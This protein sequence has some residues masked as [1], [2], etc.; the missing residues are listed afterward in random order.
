MI[1]LMKL[2]AIIVNS[3]QPLSIVLKSFIFDAAGVLGPPL[4]I[5]NFTQTKLFF[6]LK[7]WVLLIFIFKIIFFVKH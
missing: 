3:F 1:F 2:F 7:Q 5:A 4:R 6:E